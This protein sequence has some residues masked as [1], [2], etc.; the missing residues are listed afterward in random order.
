MTIGGGADTR[1]NVL[2]P[3]VG[4]INRPND[5]SKSLSGES[6]EVARILPG[7]GD[8]E[9]N[10]INRMVSVTESYKDD[11]PYS[12]FPSSKGSDYNSNSFAYGVLGAMGAK[13]VPIPKGYSLPG[14]GKPLP[15]ENFCKPSVSGCAR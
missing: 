11:K 4:D 13:N 7:K 5:V 15:A 1:A 14:A 9:N 2:G 6:L 12:L 8:S 10:L 3:L